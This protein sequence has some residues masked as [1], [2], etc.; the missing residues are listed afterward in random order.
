MHLEDVGRRLGVAHRLPSRSQQ[1]TVGWYT[2]LSIF[3][4]DV[5]EQSIHKKFVKNQSKLRGTK[6]SPV[7]GCR[8]DR[9]GY[10]VDVG[11]EGGVVSVCRLLQQRVLLLDQ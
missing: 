2:H 8:Y 7:A 4:S 6:I 10:G 5:V 11:S 9:R 1:W 3:F